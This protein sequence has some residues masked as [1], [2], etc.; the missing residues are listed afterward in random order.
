MTLFRYFFAAL[1]IAF[2]PAGVT[3]QAAH[4]EATTIIVID[5]LRIF[6]DSRAGKDVDTKLQNI[7]T[8]LDNELAPFRQSLQA[9]AESL[10]PRL[11]GK[12]PEMIGADQAL[13]NELNTFQQRRQELA[14]RQQ[15]A[16]QEFQ[17]TQQKALV[18]FN[19]AL[20]PVVLEVMRERSAQIVIEKD[21]ALA[22]SDTVD[23]SASVIAKLDQRTPAIAVTR[24]RLPAQPQQ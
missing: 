5:E 10:E 22:V 4:A 16:S 12:T 20:E 8:Q 15:V 1:A 18:D 19:N 6:R 14:Q 13:V 21:M 17:L 9:L 11:Q 3:L 2:A 7:R 23:A 24:Q